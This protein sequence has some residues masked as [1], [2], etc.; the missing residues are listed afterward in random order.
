VSAAPREA[1]HSGTTL[2]D[3]KTA[4]IVFFFL[5]HSSMRTRGG[6]GGAEAACADAEK[7]EENK[8]NCVHRI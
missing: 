5:V 7:K 8:E 2:A 6:S 1:Q 3:T 4:H